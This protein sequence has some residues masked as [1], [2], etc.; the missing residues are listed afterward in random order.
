MRLVLFRHGTAMDRELALQ[1]N[2]EDW[3]RPLT[4]KGR[5]RTEKMAKALKDWDL[6][7]DLLVSSPLKRA[8]QTADI[9]QN[10]I[11]IGER[12]ESSELVPSAPPQAFTKWLAGHSQN[13]VSVLAVGHEPQLS[14]F[15]SWALA[16]QMATFIDLKKSGAICLELESFDSIKPGTA[17]LS[18]LLG[19][20]QLGK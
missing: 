16:A 4:E 15:A 11:G 10:T 8:Q 3:R 13:A 9:L 12:F 2:V 17:E 5:E 1:Q 7:F 20:K 14:V 18:W 19:P 6:S